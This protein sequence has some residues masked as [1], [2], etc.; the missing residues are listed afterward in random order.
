MGKKTLQP[1]WFIFVV[2]VSYFMKLFVWKEVL[3]DYTS[4]IAFALA[5]NVEDARKQI[6]D[7][8]KKEEGYMSDELKK[9]LFDE[10]III[11]KSEGFYI[12]GG[13]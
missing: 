13:G 1:H 7:K 10:P 4:G 8:Y 2:V 11:D 3:R 12:W 5:D 9:D 6:A